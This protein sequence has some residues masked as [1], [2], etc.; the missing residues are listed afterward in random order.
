M[1]TPKRT[2]IGA[3]NRGVCEGHSSVTTEIEETRIAAADLRVGMFVCRLDRPW[4]STPFPLQGF[5]LRMQDDLRKL[6]ELCAYV[7]IDR[8]REATD[9][10]HTL[11]AG[12]R[13]PEQRFT[14]VTQYADKISVEEELP[15]AR[16][17]LRT[18][19]ELIDRIY[20]DVA[21]GRDFSVEDV[22]HAVRPIVAS[23][24][25]SADAFLCLEG[26]RRHDS[27]T[28]SHAIACSA[29]AAAFGRH[30]GLHE[31]T[32]FSLAAGGLLMD[33]GKTRVPQHLLQSTQPL[34]PAEIETVR[35]HVWHGL[36]IVAGAGVNDLDVISVLHTH[37]ERHNGEG[38]PERLSGAAIPVAGRMLGIID[39]YDAM[40]S[41][42]PYRAPVSRHQALQHIY[43]AR[44]SLFQSE[45][46]EQFQACLGV[47][48]T[49]SLVELSSGEIAVVMMQNRVRRLRPRVL[50]LTTPDKRPLSNFLPFD[51]LNQANDRNAVQIARSVAAGEHGIDTAGLLTQ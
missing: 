29:L 9:H 14:R 43:R 3:V 4:E 11:K 46:V 5:E 26:M 36:E 7:Y 13:R 38:Y 35:T 50:L 18:A 16:E 8:R 28:Y 40:I 20:A 41:A 1:P 12:D 6:R 47:Y 31:D 44:D 21:S 2:R 49:G 22:E 24:L 45:L 51:L 25:R 10:S 42:R 33:V 19:A 39:S 37:H 32:V 23:V 34:S 48:P 15:N 27:Y 17:A 30:M